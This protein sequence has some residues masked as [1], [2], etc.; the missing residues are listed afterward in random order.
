MEQRESF[1]QV[2]LEKPDIHMPTKQ[3]KGVGGMVQVVEHCVANV[4]PWIPFSVLQ[5]NQTK[6][7]QKKPK[8]NSIRNQLNQRPKGRTQ[9]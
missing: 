7:K 3:N 8:T 5:K 2:V 1:W 6:T 9:N 4:S